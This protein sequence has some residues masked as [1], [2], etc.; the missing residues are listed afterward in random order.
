[1]GGLRWW[2]LSKYLARLGWE[3]TILAEGDPAEST[4]PPGVRVVRVARRRTLQDRYQSWRSRAVE[5]PSSGS[6]SAGE[7]R[8]EASSPDS[9]VLGRARREVAEVLSFPDQARGW[10]SRAAIAGGRLLGTGAP[11]IIV[12]SGPPHSL[13]AV[14]RIIGRTSDCRFVMDYRD[15]WRGQPASALGGVA[16]ALL[17]DRFVRTADLVT[18]TTPE[19]VAGVLG[20]DPE[21]N[22]VWL[23][24]GAD[25]ESLPGREVPSDV[26][27]E[28]LH[29]GTLY[30]NR[31]PVP[32]LRAFAHFQAVDPRSSRSA[33]LRFV[34]SVE[35]AH[36]H[37]VEAARAAGL[38]DRIALEPPLA[39]HDALRLLARTHLAVVLAIRQD[40][41]V[42]AK[43][44]E[45]VAM[46]VPTLVI[47]ETGSATA[48]AAQRVGAIHHAPD[49]LDG[50]ART[51]ARAGRGELEPDPSTAATV[52]HSGLAAQAD[53]LFLDLLTTPPRRRRRAG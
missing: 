31:T 43:L 15:P 37:A 17:E 33:R 12:S 35:P 8:S 42:P 20:R 4:A 14:A 21:A 9:S 48:R 36:R 28:I 26:G 29:L 22:A 44:F 41:L 23:S 49:D 7:P 19:L 27:P 39:R 40:E 50:M 46:G 51:F 13:H 6:R 1:V 2:G 18:C 25:A 53:R 30:A 34:G 32:L 24:N 11:D 5:V 45:S 16:L 52:S 47:S 3:V 38:A 10:L